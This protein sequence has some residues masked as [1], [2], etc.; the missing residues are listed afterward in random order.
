MVEQ[1]ESK[2][3]RVGW[4]GLGVMGGNMAKH[5]IPKG[6]ELSVFTRT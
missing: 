2:I 3:K 5:I 4:I 1:A 6:Y